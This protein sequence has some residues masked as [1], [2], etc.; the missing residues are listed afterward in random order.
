MAYEGVQTA[1]PGATAAG[2]L[3][4]KQYYCVVKNTTDRQY[5]VATA[6]GEVIDGILQNKPNAANVPANIAMA[7]VSRVVADETL[8]AGNLWGTSADGQAKIIESSN[9][10]ADVGDFVM[11]RVIEGAASGALATVTI[12]APQYKVE[13]A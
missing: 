9:T 7:G 13:S 2:N 8:T 4:T 12:G 3:S 10:G 11:G 1:I 5:A 6:D